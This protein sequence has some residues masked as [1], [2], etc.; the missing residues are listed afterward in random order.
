M[1]FASGILMVEAWNYFGTQGDRLL[2]AWI[3]TFVNSFVYLVDFGLNY[4]RYR[5]PST[6]GKWLKCESFLVKS[7]TQCSC[8]MTFKLYPKTDNQINNS[9]DFLR[10]L[11][12]TSTN[13]HNHKY[14]KTPHEKKSVFIT[15]V[16]DATLNFKITFHRIE[17]RSRK[18]IL[19][20]ELTCLQLITSCHYLH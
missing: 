1:F 10:P 17:I 6:K 20:R 13:S 4:S 16:P 2:V 7:S 18:C 5:W 8:C 19:W 11:L 12:R 3:L 14:L 15:S 9:T